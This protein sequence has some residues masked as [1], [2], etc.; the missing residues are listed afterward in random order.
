MITSKDYPPCGHTISKRLVSK[1]LDKLVL[2]KIKVVTI[3]TY[4]LRF[5][6]MNIGIYSNKITTFCTQMPRHGMIS[7][8]IKGEQLLIWKKVPFASAK[9]HHKQ[10]LLAT[11]RVGILGGVNVAARGNV[12]NSEHRPSTN[13][14]AIVTQIS[15]QQSQKK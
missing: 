11:S 15:S 12:I 7:R 9:C 2:F 13:D 5:R 6:A 3:V 10:S 4:S 8:E 1:T 14:C